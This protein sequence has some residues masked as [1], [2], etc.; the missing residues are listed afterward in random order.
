MKEKLKA[1]IFWI[2]AAIVVL[3]IILVLPLMMIE[4][5]FGW[6]KKPFMA[7]ALKCVSFMALVE[8]KLDGITYEEELKRASPGRVERLKELWNETRM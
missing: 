8:A 3:L 4:V 7:F 2:V 5:C 1:A 6:Q